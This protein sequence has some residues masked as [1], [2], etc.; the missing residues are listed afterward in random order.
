METIQCSIKQSMGQRGLNECKNYMDLN[1]NEKTIYQNFWNVAQPEIR[2][3]L[4]AL[5]AIV[6]KEEK[7]QINNLSFHLK[8]IENED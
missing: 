3:N 8:N 2:W 4:I 5:I 1:K 7:Y 6:R